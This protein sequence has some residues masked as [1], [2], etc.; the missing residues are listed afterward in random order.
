MQQQYSSKQ[1]FICQIRSTR[2]TRMPT[3][4]FNPK[5]W[6]KLLRYVTLLNNKIKK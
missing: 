6:D 4:M 5:Q 2:Y 3:T 1:Q